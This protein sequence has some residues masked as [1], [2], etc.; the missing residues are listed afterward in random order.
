M[1]EFATTFAARSIHTGYLFRGMEKVP[2]TVDEEPQNRKSTKK[3]K[4]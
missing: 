3:T 4:D 2:N 1:F